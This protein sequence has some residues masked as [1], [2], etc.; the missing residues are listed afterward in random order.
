MGVVLGCATNS[1]NERDAAAPALAD[2]TSVNSEARDVILSGPPCGETAPR[3]G[4]TLRRLGTGKPPV[5][6]YFVDLQV[7]NPLSSPV[8]LL[9]DGRNVPGTLTTT[10]L[11]RTS[12]AS[13]G[14]FW[15][16]SGSRST[17]AVRIPGGAE[18]RLR[19]VELSTSKH[20]DSIPMAFASD[21]RIADRTATDWL[22]HEGLNPARGEFRLEKESLVAERSV[23]TLERV[24]VSLHVICVQH[25]D[26]RVPVVP[27]DESSVP[28]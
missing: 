10:Q 12:R 16:L 21:L 23:G 11:W 8:W 17:V 5:Q 22:G 28:P 2:R 18:L 25:V 19:D 6:Y 1:V 14:F 27:D 4:A 7:T 13:P 20:E 26:L 15:L 9:L 3:V 24:R